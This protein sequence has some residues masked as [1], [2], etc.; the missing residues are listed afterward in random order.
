MLECVTGCFQNGGLVLDQNA[1]N[2]IS[3][4]ERP[5]KE[6]MGRV[7]NEDPRLSEVL[8]IEYCGGSILRHIRKQIGR[9]LY[10]KKKYNGATFLCR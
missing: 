7:L 5:W 4:S 6:L 10:E 9:C 1:L 2:T 8:G 3:Q